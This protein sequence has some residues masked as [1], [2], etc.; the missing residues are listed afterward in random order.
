MPFSQTE[1]SR[2]TGSGTS[3]DWVSRPLSRI[4]LRHEPSLSAPTTGNIMLL[5]NRHSRSVPVAAARD[6]S[7]K[8]Q[9]EQTASASMPDGTRSRPV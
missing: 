7:G 2:I 5:V 4:M 1:P 8:P 3:K 9:L 6:H